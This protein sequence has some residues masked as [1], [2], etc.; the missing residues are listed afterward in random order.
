[1]TQVGT[2]NLTFDN[3]GNLTTDDQGHTLVYDA[4]NE[5]VAVK[6]GSTTLVS[7]QYDALGRRIVEN[8]GTVH[9][10]YYDAAWQVVEERWGGVSTAT[11]QY[12]WSPVYVDALVLRDRSTQNNGTLDER[13]WVQ[14]EANYN[15]TALYNG[16][17]SVVERY[18]YDPYGK[19]TILDANFNT[20]SSSSYAFVNGFQGLR[21]DTTSGIYNARFR[22][23][24]PTLGRWTQADP[25]GFGG[26]DTN[27]YRGLANSPETMSDP[28]GLA[29]GHHYLPVS[30]IEALAEF[31]SAGAVDVAAGFYTGRTSPDHFNLTYGGVKHDEYS[32][33]VKE[34]LEQYIKANG[35]TKEKPMTPEQMQEFAERMKEGKLHDGS[36]PG[37]RSK[38]RLIKQF[39][40]AVEKER[41]AFEA[42]SKGRAKPLPCSKE[43][44][45][46]RGKWYREQSGRFGSALLLALLFEAASGS[47]AVADAA[48]NS[49][50]FRKGI[51]ALANGDLAGANVSMVGGGDQFGLGGFVAD[52]NA[53]GAAKEA[54][55]FS[56]WWSKQV[57]EVV[58][59]G[60]KLE[61]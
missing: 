55:W 13:L 44:N 27:F 15:V 43:D 26:G 4:W 18:V 48:A 28:G 25:L 19:R 45:I 3:N 59:R 40:D 1:V 61:K 6:S 11:I 21:L 34:Q 36:V 9:D 24:S 50:N 38:Y 39:N 7:Y 53:A 35:I 58:R 30:V 51:E 47:V 17:G 33:L 57:S 37:K 31:I 41:R 16:S 60:K 56:D 2:S 32:K 14:Q 10:L 22:D 29:V 52:I 5:L 8:P 54:A 12:V 49:S 23:L 42:A 46:K 20:R